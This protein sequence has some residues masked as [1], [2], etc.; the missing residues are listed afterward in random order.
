MLF[1]VIHKCNPNSHESPVLLELRFSVS[2]FA[3][4]WRDECE[5]AADL[6]H[7]CCT[8][9]GRPQAEALSVSW[10]RHLETPHLLVYPPCLRARL[11]N[12]AL[13]KL[14]GTGRALQDLHSAGLC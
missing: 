4:N 10:L 1:R 9:H 6:Q 13:W 8:R 14:R 12:F 2:I 7:S 3:G 11:F 5:A